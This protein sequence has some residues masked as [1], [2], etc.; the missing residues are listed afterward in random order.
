MEK[1]YSKKKPELLL[2]IVHRLS[3]IKTIREDVVP[4]EEFIQMATMQLPKGKTFKPHKHKSKNISVVIPQESWMIISG[5]VKC[6][7]YDIDDT[8]IAEPILEGGDCS[9]SLSGGHNYEVLEDCIVREYKV[10]PYLGI[11][12]DKVFINQ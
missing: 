10:G 9:I 1:F 12:S 7:F 11:E 2:H 3:D 5:K 4:A 6:I 8:I